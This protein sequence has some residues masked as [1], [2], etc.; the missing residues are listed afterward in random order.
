MLEIHKNDNKGEFLDI[1]EFTLY[2]NLVIFVKMAISVKSSKTY[3]GW[4]RKFP[5]IQPSYNFRDFPRNFKIFNDGKSQKLIRVNFWILTNSSYI[6][7]LNFFMKMVIIGII[8]LRKIAKFIFRVNWSKSWNQ[9][10]LSFFWFFLENDNL[11]LKWRFWNFSE[12]SLVI[13]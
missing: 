6:W 5:K 13:L 9:L 1:N 12:F 3:I 2:M 7:F 4:I 8:V 10:Y 11:G